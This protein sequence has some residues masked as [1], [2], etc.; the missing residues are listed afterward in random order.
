LSGFNVTIVAVAIGAALLFVGLPVAVASGLAGVGV[1]LFALLVGLTP[2]VVRAS[3]MAIM[4]LLARIFSRQYAAMP[5]LV[6]AAFIMVMINPHILLFD[7]SF[8]LS[9]IATA[10]LISFGDRVS[11]WLTALPARFGIRE[12]ATATVSAQLAVA[13]LLVF[14]TGKLSLISFMA[15][16]LVL[17]V[18]PVLMA[19]GTA[20]ALSGLL[21]EN[22]ALPF[23]AASYGVASYI[24]SVVDTLA[25]LSFA[26]ATLG[27]VPLLLVF[28]SYALLVYGLRRPSAG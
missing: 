13:P 12:A 4:A 7:P 3:I 11:S 26:T 16:L 24:F 18:V 15:N 17:P 1:G 9:A 14:Y 25:S 27:R 2:T 10:G 5:G 6:L 23:A 19:T 20:T 22:L 21:L 28:L 8:Q